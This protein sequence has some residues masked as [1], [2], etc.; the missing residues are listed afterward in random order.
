M[1]NIAIANWKMYPAKLSDAKRVADNIHKFTSKLKCEVVICPPTPFVT[2]II[3]TN[4]ISIGAQDASFEK[5]G[6]HTGEVSAQQ[7]RSV[8]VSYVIVGHSERRAKGETSE[9]VAK[10]AVAVL[11]AR[12]SPVI[13]IGEK[14]RRHEGEHWQ[15]ISH[16]LRASLADVPKSM[17]SRCVIAYEPIWAIGTG[18][19]AMQPEAIGEAAIFIRKVLAEIYGVRSSAKVRVIYGGSVDFKNASSIASA[20]GV[21]G[22][23]VGRQSLVPKYF[24][25]IASSLR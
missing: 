25:R 21:S 3:K 22:F 18:K 24:A 16:E 8:G 23:L 6:A 20:P 11:K 7:L 17:I 19:T 9:M 14:E 10:K 5:E 1:R 4:R 12:M 15:V 2:S 13:C